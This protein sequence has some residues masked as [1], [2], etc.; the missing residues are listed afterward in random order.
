[1]KN[2]VIIGVKCKTDNIKPKHMFIGTQV[3][4]NFIIMW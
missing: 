1:M 3:Q 2:L 4:T